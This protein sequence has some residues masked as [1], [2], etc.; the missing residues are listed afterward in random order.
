M[1]FTM[2][3]ADLHGLNVFA[4][5]GIRPQLS[6][7]NFRAERGSLLASATDGARA[8]QLR[9]GDSPD[10]PGAT[11]PRD[12]VKLLPKR[13][14]VTFVFADGKVTADCGGRQTT[15]AV[16]TER[17]PPFDRLAPVGTPNP[18]PAEVNPELLG[19]FVVAARFMGKRNRVRWVTRGTSAAIVCS[20]GRADVWGL[21]MPYVW[22]GEDRPLDPVVPDWRA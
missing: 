5:D 9:L 15:A 14:E 13:G 10:W 22:L 20:T 8:L 21:V 18:E 11:A 19:D 6:G 4:G 17:F 3:A 2:Q 12:F 16:L 7:V 1:M